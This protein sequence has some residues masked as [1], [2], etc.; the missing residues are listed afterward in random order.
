ML[1]KI[2]SAAVLGINAFQVEVEVDLYQG[3]P[4]FITVGLPDGAVKESR[5]ES[6][7]L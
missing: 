7:Q 6:N 1:A 3:M 5:R 2:Q 4:K